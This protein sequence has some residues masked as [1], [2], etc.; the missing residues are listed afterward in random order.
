MRRTMRRTVIRTKARMRRTM[1]RTVIRRKTKMREKR[2]RKSRV[3]TR[4]VKKTRR[5]RKRKKRVKKRMTRRARRVRKKRVK[6]VKKRMTRRA[7]RMKKREKKR[8]REA[9]MSKVTQNRVY[10]LRLFQAF[11]YLLVKERTVR[12]TKIKSAVSVERPRGMLS[13]L[14]IIRAVCRVLDL[15]QMCASTLL[16][17]F[18]L[19]ADLL[20]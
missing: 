5:V 6:R 15:R 11:G 10:T 18:L 9:T 2:R 17:I 4:R 3:R 14:S 8:T 12:G 20:I 1:R 19:V 16:R 7:R 13:S